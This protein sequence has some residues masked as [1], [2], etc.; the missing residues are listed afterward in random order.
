M[1][2]L[3]IGKGDKGLLDLAKAEVDKMTADGTP[4]KGDG[5][6][7][8]SIGIDGITASA[9][10]G[11]GKGWSVGIWAKRTWDRAW[12]AAAKITGRF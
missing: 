10:V 2:D 5:A 3:K 12:G 1:S 9:E 6:V 4:A 11:V 8:V 7:D